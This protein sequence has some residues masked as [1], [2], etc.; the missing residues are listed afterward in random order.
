MVKDT[1]FTK[2]RLL[3]LRGKIIDLTIPKVMGILNVTPDS[4]YDGGMWDKPDQMKKRV[5]DLLTEGADIIDVGAFSSRP[6][7]NM[8]SEDEELQR[9]DSALGILRKEFPDAILSV[10]TCRAKVARIVC[11]TYNVEI[12]NDISGGTLDP[13]MAETIASLQVPYIMMHMPGNPATMQS[14]TDYENVVRE[15][16]EF[17]GGQSKYFR[18]LGIKDII[19]DPGFGFGK[20]LEQNYRLLYH[21][22]E[23]RMLEQPILVGLS[24]KSMIYRL[25][26]ITPGEA[27][28][29]TTA[30]HMMAL[31]R[32]ADILRVHD[33]KEAKQT[34]QL[35]L[36]AREEGNKQ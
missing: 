16:I 21:L 2:K 10:D 12:I 17:L 6:G 5:N 33:V 34:I 36:K 11:S 3:N 27:L 14:M 23:F 9:L 32:G 24:R 7:A 18:S 15:I 26:N 20:T 31:E 1:F 29:G 30:L 35:F 19:V 4:F 22:D 25:L 13:E 28:T 8:V